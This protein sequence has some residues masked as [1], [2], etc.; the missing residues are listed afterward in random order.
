M[1]PVW[2]MLNPM[3]SGFSAAGAIIAGAATAAEAASVVLVNVLLVMERMFFS[4]CPL[5]FMACEGKLP[6]LHTSPAG[7][8]RGSSLSISWQDGLPGQ[9]R[10]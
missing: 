6:A 10:Q 9:A 2:A 7:L 1:P 3:R 8:I 5:L 4:L